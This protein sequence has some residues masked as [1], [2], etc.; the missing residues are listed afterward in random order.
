MYIYMYLFTCSLYFTKQIWIINTG[1]PKYSVTCKN[2]LQKIIYIL[3]NG[4]KKPA[5]TSCTF[6]M[7][8]YGSLPF[9]NSQ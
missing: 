9:I 7:F 3:F 2:I 5:D 1:S 8:K 4:H 6:Y